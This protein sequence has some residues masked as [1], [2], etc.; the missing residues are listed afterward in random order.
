MYYDCEEIV[1]ELSP[2]LEKDEWIRHYSIETE[3]AIAQG[4]NILVM[5]NG[6]TGNQAYRLL[7]YMGFMESVVNLF[8]GAKMNIV[9]CSRNESTLTNY[10]K[11]AV[12]V[13]NGFVPLSVL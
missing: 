11:W 5:P 13:A 7:V 4:A 12:A 2:E 1:Q 8:L 9:T 10:F 6:M 3:F